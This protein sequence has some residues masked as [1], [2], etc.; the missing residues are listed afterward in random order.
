M[1]LVKTLAGLHRWLVP[2]ESGQGW[3]V[4]LWLIYLNFFFI[5]WFFRPFIGGEP[6]LVTL[7]IVLF[8]VLYFSAWRRR[9]RVALM[10]IVLIAALAVAWADRSAGSSVFFIYAA[11]F[12]FLVGRPRVSVWVVFGIAAVAAIT[13]W[14]QQP[15]LFYWL[16]GVVISVMIGAA[17]IFFGERE[18]QNAELRLTQAEVRRLARVAERERIAR[19]LHD[20]LGHTLSLITVKSELARRLIDRDSER[21]REELCSIEESARTA[22][23]EVRQ[24]ISGFNEQKLD[25]ALEQARLTLRAADVQLDLQVDHQLDIPLPQQA[26]LSLVIREAVTN[27][28]RHAAARVCRIRLFVEAGGEL[29]LEIADDGRGTIRP[30]GNG[31]QGM[32]ARVEALG[33]EFHLGNDGGGQLVARIPMVPAP[34]AAPA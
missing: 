32:R 16:P 24:A 12:S 2:A 1:N 6:L 11:S 14:L 3:V 9:G 25:E 22:L 15:M 5:E 28:L 19:D 4:Y 18:R 20:V 13:A 27:V 21:A 33:G 26:M 17:N 10:H 30:D 31:V 29:C 8:L 34:G 7:T 23:S